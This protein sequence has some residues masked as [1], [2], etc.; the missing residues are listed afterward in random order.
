M[1][2]GKSYGELVREAGGVMSDG[3][4]KL[5]FDALVR[6]VSALEMQSKAR[7]DRE[8]LVKAGQ[9]ALDAGIGSDGRMPSASDQL[10][11]AIAEARS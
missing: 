9:R 11:D 7:E 5:S 2:H 4:A 1:S 6:F 10:R 8:A 3:Y